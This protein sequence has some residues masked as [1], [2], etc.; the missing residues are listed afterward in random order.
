MLNEGAILTYLK[1]NPYKIDVMG[2]NGYNDPP[3]IMEFIE[4]Y[5]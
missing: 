1:E 4:K 5:I 2:F 3:E